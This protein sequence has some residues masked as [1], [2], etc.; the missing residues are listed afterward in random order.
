MPEKKKRYN[1][2]E[3]DDEIVRDEVSRIF[4]KHPSDYI[5]Q[6]E[7]IGFTYY[8]DDFDDEEQEEARARPVNSNQ[9]YLV[10]FFRG[11]IPLS[12]RTIEIF[13]EER[14][15]S[16]PNS[17]L[18]RKYFKQANKHLLALLLHGLQLYPVS[19]ELL[20]DLGFFHEFRN[21]LSVLIEHYTLACEME[22]N[23]ECFSELALDFFY[24]TFPDGYDA[25]YALKEKYPLGT[26][27]RSVLDF[28]YEIENT[29][30]GD[31]GNG[32]QF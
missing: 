26:N 9:L 22:Q 12:D 14:R 1:C 3:L 13:L 15:S 8:D 17:P 29:Q 6:L 4:S 18:I 31:D 25:L 11:D 23:L 5:E 32:V 19:E 16:K 24:A 28:L 20:A 7:E 27:K 30:D 21:I 2:D 10:S